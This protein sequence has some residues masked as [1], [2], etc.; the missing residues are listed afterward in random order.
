MQ[1]NKLFKFYNVSVI[2]PIFPTPMVF[3]P[4]VF[5]SVLALFDFGT[6]YGRHSNSVD[7]VLLAQY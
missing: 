4:L 7:A 6:M 3:G 2:G 5:L 1:T